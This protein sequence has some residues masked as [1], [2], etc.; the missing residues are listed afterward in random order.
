ME[1]VDRVAP[2]TECPKPNPKR[3]LYRLTDPY[4]TFWHRFVADVKARGL[5][6]LVEPE[7][8]WTEFVVPRLDDYTGGIFE[9]TCRQVVHHSRHLTHPI[10]TIDVV[11]GCNVYTSDEGVV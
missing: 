9:D 4:L 2:I 3:T 7:R 11:H 5:A 1:V 8:L 6:S 10:T